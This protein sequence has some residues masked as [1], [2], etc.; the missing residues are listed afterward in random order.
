MSDDG[1]KAI[2]R[3]RAHRVDRQ[4]P[5]IAAA[6]DSQLEKK[7]VRKLD[8]VI[9][10]LTCALYLLAYLDRSNLGYVPETL[11]FKVSPKMFLGAIRRGQIPAVVTSKLFRPRI[12]IG[13]ATIGW[14]LA[15]TLQAAAFNFQGLLATRFF[16]GVFEAGFGPMI[17][18]YYTFFYTKHEMGVRL[19]ICFEWPDGGWASVW[20]TAHQFLPR[21]L[22]DLFL[23]EGC[24]T[25]ALGILTLFTLPDRP[26]T[27]KWLHGAQ[28]DLAIER[29]SRGG[30]KEEAGTLNNRFEGLEGVCVRVIYFGVNIA[31]ASIGVFLPTIIK[32]FGYTNAKAQLLTVPPYAVAAV[33]M[34]G[35]SYMSDRTQNRGFFMASASAV[36]ALGYLWVLPLPSS[37]YTHIRN[38]VT[39][40]Q[41]VTHNL[42]SES[43]KAAGIPLFM[44]I[45][46][47][48]SVLG[49][50]SYPASEGPH[51]I[52]LWIRVLGALMCLVLTIS[53]RLE[54]ARRDR[55]YGPPEEG[56]VVDTRELA[57][58]SKF[59]STYAKLL[60]TPATVPPT[61]KR[62][63]DDVF[64]LSP[65]IS[66]LRDKMS[67]L[68]RAGLL[69]TH[70]HV[71]TA[72][73]AAAKDEFNAPRTTAKDEITPVE[74][75][76]NNTTL[77]TTMS[78]QDKAH[79]ANSNG[80]DGQDATSVLR[81]M[82]ATRT[83]QAVAQ[84]VLAI[85]GITGWE[86]MDVMAGGVGVS[87]AVFT[88]LVGSL[89]DTMGN[90]HESDE[91]RHSALQLTLALTC[92]FG[93]L[94]PGAYL[95]AQDMFPAIV[96]L[97]RSPTT[98]RY[99]FEA[100]LLL[101]IL[102]NYHRADAA[103]LN[104][105]LKHIQ[106]TDDT[107]LIHGLL[108]VTR[109]AC[110][111]SVKAYRDIH[112]D[113]PSFTS[114]MS[115]IFSAFRPAAA[116]PPMK[117]LFAGQPIEASVVLFPFFEYMSRNRV[118]RAMLAETI[119]PDPIKSQSRPTSPRLQTTRPPLGSPKNTG[120]PLGSPRSRP[121]S[122]I[123]AG[124]TASMASIVQKAH[125]NAQLHQNVRCVP[126]F[127]SLASYILAHAGS[128]SSG[129][130]REEAYA[131][132]ILDIL[133]QCVADEGIMRAMCSPPTEGD[134]AVWLCRQ[135]LKL[136]QIEYHWNELWRTI[137]ATLVFVLA[138]Q[139]VVASGTIPIEQII[140]GIVQVLD[141]AVACA[142]GFLPTPEAVH[143]LVYEMV[144]ASPTLQ[145]LNER[146]QS[147]KYKHSLQDL[148]MTI[149]FYEDQLEG[150]NSAD[151]VMRVLAREIERDGVHGVST[152]ERE[153][154]VS[155]EYLDS[156]MASRAL[157]FL[158]A[159][160]DL[161]NGAT[162][163]SARAQ[164]FNGVGGSGAWWPND[165]HHF[166]ESVKRN[167]SDLLFSEK[168]LGL[169][170]YRYNLGGG[171]L[172]VST[173]ARAPETFYV[174]QGPI[175]CLRQQRPRD[176]T[177]NGQSCGGLFKTG[178]EAGYGQY[179]A[180]TLDHIINT[181]R[182]PVSYLSPFNEPDNSFGPVPCGQEGMQTN[183]NQRAAV[184][185]GIYNK[186]V[187]KGLQSKVGIMADES[188]N[189]G[190]AQNEYASWLPQVL[191]K[192]AVICH[193]TYD[194]PTDANYLSY[195]NYVKSIAPNKETWM[196]EVCCSVGAADASDRKWSGGYDPTIRGGLHFATMM[197]QSFIVVQETHYDF[198]TL[199]SSSTHDWLSPLG[200]PSCVNS[201]NTSGW[202]D[203]LI[204]YDPNYAQNGNFA[205]YLTKHYWTM[206]HFGNFV[207]PGFVRHAV[208]GSNT[209]IL[210]VESDTAFTLLAINPYTTQTTIPVSFQDTSL[211]LQATHTYRTSATEDFASVGL[212]V[213][214][215]GS[216]SLIL[217]PTSLTTWVFS[218][219]K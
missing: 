93:Q 112:D 95:L 106:E 42:G 70:Q 204:Y 175:D 179:I 110:S 29:M 182:I 205:L 68:G 217:A 81:R 193:H 124:R 30:M 17:P 1:A 150:T 97:I 185:N 215:N 169:S 195:V 210:A 116:P 78:D 174:S 56:K 64:C 156:Q 113:T 141:L 41:V 35:V 44:V 76:P 52:M 192:I 80:G 54:N 103:S 191:D 59:I 180:D 4:W 94:S 37:A 38:S 45:G 9:L 67:G 71:I 50:H 186:L 218:K 43:K 49:T 209:R 181:L 207:K 109:Y 48:G 82:N 166:P 107:V 34:M 123:M 16:L 160:F 131:G 101:A 104:P 21:K 105:Y 24:P 55:V 161:V 151:N 139:D 146:E 129:A 100:F 165:L 11:V 102:A 40:E 75:S 5:N 189:L 176:F 130:G 126:E 77:Q 53:F 158:P 96:S 200:N 31:L 23:V 15:S 167:L 135:M 10:P 196:S 201:I 111:R 51:Y 14:G 88:E 177:T 60:Q 119:H 33:V 145:Q 162:V 89:M 184:I 13:C 3:N 12:W 6:V 199:L 22:E 87:D 39:K 86:I 32:T 157:I 206:K 198:W 142:D 170:S 25:I 90:D 153:E 84:A 132:L 18:L 72:I 148:L 62:F 98:T 74:L 28:K 208:D 173:P 117:E 138:K 115:S 61:E 152:R 140:V 172:G 36:G 8:A 2:P 63:W 125:A 183:P 83:L 79:V 213:L 128:T 73:F 108:W 58:K 178:T 202:Q 143:Q 133:E 203:G 65:D 144:R 149:E 155:V 127:V 168:G 114:T 137:I 190:L 99:S 7:L 20:R 164:T 66:W 194:F 197:M 92:G 19:S 47:C 154:P 85:P 122:L 57:D 219:V 159:L 136:E 171:G 163:L 46:Q 120:T 118:F 188:S 26:D 121:S 216:W 91:M 212:P 69:G 134:S 187:T 211:R 27:T 214:S 147:G